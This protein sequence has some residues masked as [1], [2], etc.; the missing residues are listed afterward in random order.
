MYNQT[1]YTAN[2]TLVAP[3]ETAVNFLQNDAGAA[4]SDEG[5]LVAQQNVEVLLAGAISRLTQKQWPYIAFVGGHGELNEYEAGDI[6]QQL[7]AFAYLDRVTLNG[8]VDALSGYDAVVIAKPT[9][10]WNEADKLVVDQYIM[11]GG[12][13]AWFIDAV[14]VHHDSLANGHVTFAMECDHRLDDQLFKYGIRINPTIISDLQ[15]A[16]LPVNIA[17]AGQTAD[18]KPAPW[19]YYPLLVP[20]AGNSITQGL[21][22]V[23]AKYPS[24]IDTV[25]KNSAVTKKVLLHSSQYSRTQTIPARI[26]LSTITQRPDP[27]AF[28]QSFLPVAVALEGT[29]GSAFLNRPL[30]SYNNQQ[31]FDFKT[32]SAATKMIVVADGDIIR[33]DVARRADGDRIFPL[34]FDR[35]M[36]VQFGNRRFVEN[37]IYYLLDDDNTIN[38]RPREWTMRLLDRAK[39][40]PQRTYWT[41]VNTAIPLLLVLAAGALFVTLR[42][43]KYGKRPPVKSG[44]PL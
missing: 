32:K 16:Y 18:F 40:Y 7:A 17:P 20:P 38:I 23:E 31:P 1:V 5:L 29:F 19:V 22:L 42:K 2:D 33:N 27:E 11:N 10:A 43:Y 24:H 21:N 30:Q 8:D 13:V 12:R 28:R 34:G 35:Y 4:S 44:T 15:C 14:N 25:G 9:T 3:R 37:C 6:C 36:N 39:I 26:S 41:V